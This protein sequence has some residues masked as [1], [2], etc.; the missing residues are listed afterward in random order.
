MPDIKENRTKPAWFFVALILAGLGLIS[1]CQADPPHCLPPEAELPELRKVSRRITTNPS[2][3]PKQ[4][5]KLM[6]YFDGSGSMR[7]FVPKNQER[8]GYLYCEFVE[9]LAKNRYLADAQVQFKAFGSCLREINVSRELYPMVGLVKNGRR[10]DWYRRREPES[11]GNARLPFNAVSR[12]DLVLEEIKES[13][14]E[15]LSVVVTDLFLSHETCVAEVI[16]TVDLVRSIMTGSENTPPKTIGIMGVVSRFEGRIDDLPGIPT[17]SLNSS[18]PFYILVIGENKAVVNLLSKLKE[19]GR[20]LLAEDFETKI[21]TAVFLPNPIS[22]TITMDDLKQKDCLT[23]VGATHTAELVKCRERTHILSEDQQFNLIPGQKGNQIEIKLGNEMLP[24][25]I[26][27]SH[28]RKTREQWWRYH[29][30]LS[31]DCKEK[32][33]Y[34]GMAGDSFPIKSRLVRTAEGDWKVLLK[35]PGSKKQT[36]RKIFYGEITLGIQRL[37]ARN[38]QWM[39]AWNQDLNLPIDPGAEFQRTPHLGSLHRTMTTLMIHKLGNRDFALLGL[40]FGIE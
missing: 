21:K 6:I 3:S 24:D 19:D 29:P 34:L 12:L 36:T 7:G 4:P 27:V 18:L 37:N 20:F 35:G 16:P 26:E 13:P 10:H 39:R 40:A 17:F 33:R 25:C 28:M 22:K 23:T 14:P 31:G 9:M 2:V 32:W 8:Q 11:D 30:E 5:Q 1:A 38:S 15:V